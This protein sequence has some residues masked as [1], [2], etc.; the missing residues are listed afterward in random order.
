MSAK[1]N[2]HD[3][4][5]PSAHVHEVILNRWS[6]RA[7]SGE[8]VSDTDLR[9]LFEAA[10]WAPS[11]FNGQPWRFLYA[12]KGSPHWDTF[13][14]LMVE[15]N[16]SWAKNA[17]VLIVVLSRTTTESSGKPVLTHSFDTGAAWENL[18]LQATALGLVAHG[19]Q[20]FNYDRAREALGVP[21]HYAVEAMIAVGHPG[22]PADLPEALRE[23]EQ[24]SGRK[25][26]DEI[27]WEGPFGDRG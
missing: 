5:Q 3:Y 17:G 20:G 14:D 27:A 19:M 8:A 24:P 18:A 26:I 11:A 23:R 1:I 25:T 10:R 15:F 7:L 4:R 21:E 22:D 9:S 13:F 2:V 12:R 16:Q 6:P